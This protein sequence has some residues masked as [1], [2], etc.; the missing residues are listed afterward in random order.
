MDSLQTSGSIGSWHKK[1]VMQ[2]YLVRN[3]HLLV[4]WD[5]NLCLV[6]RHNQDLPAIEHRKHQLSAHTNL[7]LL[8]LVTES[9]EFL[10]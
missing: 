1:R 5:R 9:L 6:H 10:V 4:E 2:Q 3:R 7:L 8:A